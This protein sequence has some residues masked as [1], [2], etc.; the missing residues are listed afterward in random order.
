MM[1]SV[2][3]VGGLL[4]L[5]FAAVAF[6]AGSG[7]ISWVFDVA[8]PE[9]TGLGMAGD[10]NMTQASQL[11]LTPVNSFVQ[12]MSWMGGVLY[13]FGLMAIF[14]LA[15][16]F[17]ATN[18]RWIIPLFFA[19]MI[20]LIIASIF[21]SNIYESFYTGTDELALKLQAQSVLSFMILYSPAIFSI[22]G[23]LAGA[24]LFSAPG[25]ENS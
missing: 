18:E 16:A 25:A 24:L 8:M 23:F 9:F 11:T 1:A 21:I 7:I 13:I 15:F 5:L 2:Y 3:I 12:S 4:I 6:A 17:R 19:L 10:V 22:C 20:L 14:G